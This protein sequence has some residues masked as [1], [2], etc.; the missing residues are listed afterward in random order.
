MAVLRNMTKW[1]ERGRIKYAFGGWLVTGTVVVE[2]AADEFGKRKDRYWGWLETKL[3]RRV[4]EVNKPEIQI[5]PLIH[6][7]SL[8]SSL[9]CF[10]Q[11]RLAWLGSFDSSFPDPTS[12]HAQPVCF[13]QL[14]TAILPL[15]SLFTQNERKKNGH[16]SPS[17]YWLG[18]RRSHPL[19]FNTAY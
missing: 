11:F 3:Q 9:P 14:E 6:S 13:Q 7:L 5:I 4:I 17:D 1:E 2:Q 8:R 12:W 18:K 10:H 19:P 16:R 15:C